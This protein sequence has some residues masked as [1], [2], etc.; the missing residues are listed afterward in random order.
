MAST[1]RDAKAAQ[2]RRRSE[3]SNRSAMKDKVRA[4][5]SASN[6]A[7]GLECADNSHTWFSQPPGFLNGL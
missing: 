6:P 4:S 2:M 5:N 3:C 1:S 7:T